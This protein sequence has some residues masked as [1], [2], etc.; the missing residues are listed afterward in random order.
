MARRW[1]RSKKEKSI[2][3]E[4]KEQDSNSN[5]ITCKTEDGKEY[6]IDLELCRLFVED[7]LDSLAL[8]ED[9]IPKYDFGA[10]VFQMLGECI[11]IL[12]H[13]GWTVEE[14]KNQVDEHHKCDGND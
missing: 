8:Y 1:E 14:L 5:I 9:R 11:H 10:A 7:T 3:E 12:G 4:K 2:T 6:E 13:L